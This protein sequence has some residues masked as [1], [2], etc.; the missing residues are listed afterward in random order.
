MTVSVF[1]EP[2]FLR[3]VAYAAGAGAG[4]NK[5]TLD[6]IVFT[7]GMDMVAEVEGTIVAVDE[8][9]SIRDFWRGS[10][11]VPV[12]DV[13]VPFVDVLAADVGR[14]SS[15]LSKEG[16]SLNVRRENVR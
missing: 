11:P 14:G 3:K 1:G 9:K 5:G 8:A 2:L 12:I 7:F 15:T 16:L 6:L 10:V 13:P 4:A